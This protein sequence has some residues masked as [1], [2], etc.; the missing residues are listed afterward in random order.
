M[1]FYLK[2]VRA[3][4]L[5]PLAVLLCMLSGLMLF[6]YPANAQNE[7]TT[8]PT[9]VSAT[10]SRDGIEVMVTFSEDITVSPLVTTLA[11]RY[12]VS[13]GMILKYVMSLTV[14]GKDNVLITSHYSGSVV[15]LR[16]ETPNARTGQEVKVAYNNIFAQEPG[17]VLTDLSGNAVKNFDFQAVTNASVDGDTPNYG[18]QSVLD[19]LTLSICE[20]D[21]VTYGVSLPS[22]PAGSL[23]IGIFFSHWDVGYPSREYL[24]FN[25][26][27]WDTPK[28]ISV[29]TIVDKDDYTNWV[30]LYHRMDGVKITQTYEKVIRILVLE[31]GHEDCYTS[32]PATGAPMIWGAAQVG[33]TLRAD[34]YGVSDA[35]GLTIVTYSYQWLAD[36]TEITGATSDGY[37]IKPADVGKTIKVRVTFTDDAGNDESLTSG[38]TATV[39]PTA[40]D[41]PRS[42]A[43]DPAGT[44]E[45]SVTWQEPA[46]NGGAEI[47]GY[48]VQWKLAI[49]SWDTSADVSQASATGTSHTISSL[50]LDVEYT[51]RVIATNFRGDSPPSRQVTATSVTQSAQ[52]QSTEENSPA[53]GQPTISGTIQV[54]ET[55]TASTSE[56]V[57][58][59]GLTNAAF[60]HQWIRTDDSTDAEISGATGASYTLVNDDKG[61][62]VKVRVSF[63]DDA[64]NEEALTSTATGTIAPPPLTAS[65]HT[66]H[67]PDNHDGQNTFTFELR[68]SEEFELS[69]VTLRD[70]AFKIT[71]GTVVKAKRLNPPSNLRWRITVQ[72]DSDAD[73]GIT[74][75]ITTNC[76]D[77]GAICASDSRMLSNR[78]ELTVQGPPSES[79]APTNTPATG[80]P[81]IAGTAQVGQSLQAS[82]SGIA[83]DDGLTNVTFAHQW[84]RVDGTNET[85]IASATGS[86]YALVS[87]DEGHT[88]KVRVS[89]T[90]DAGNSESLT[91]AATDTV[92]PKPNSP[93]TGQPAITGTAEVGNT[94]GVNLSAV[95]DSDG[96]TGATYSHQW[97]RGN[98]PI[99]GATDSTYTVIRA[100]GGHNV[101]VRVSFTDDDGSDETVTS[102]PVSVPRPPLTAELVRTTGTPSNHNG[103]DTFTVQLNF[104]ENFGV[105]YTTVRDHALDVTNGAVTSAA[106]VNRTGYERNQRWTMTIRPS[107]SNAIQITVRITTGCN[108][109]GAIC[110][111]DGRM[112]S[113]NETITVAGPP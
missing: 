9:F 44:G 104:S 93:A 108:D 61:K 60:A 109:E 43:A 15:T 8:P 91:S 34:T 14:D 70:N 63:T 32:T 110:T 82:T 62:T 50:Q 56:I 31:K 89:F 33:Q 35:D 21:T 99:S 18:A 5:K 13:E 46:S 1:A 72:P 84:V 48:K 28:T 49:G 96:M 55:L 25:Q 81:T 7:D 87:A 83:D 24:S 16:L 92:A 54:G 41:R 106:R 38:K 102:S 57:D 88:V 11:E 67:T 22:Q 66:D 79:S 23:G 101:K 105:S 37:L 86:S 98:S 19:R 85:D 95:S 90:D 27:N 40:P 113:S 45:L 26:E 97:F 107:S 59:D 73:V 65:V 80:T 100:D 47:T 78:S 69:Y 52:Q 4:R 64:D 10:T 74:L 17:G 6:T 20:G 30:M 71:D 77:D 76:N 51:V 58:E 53:M 12:Q 103:S 94:L 39:W 3:L 68:F 29:E 112:L 42:V 111:P 2:P 36:D 75:P